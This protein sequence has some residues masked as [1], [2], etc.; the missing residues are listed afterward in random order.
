MLITSEH[1]WNILAVCASICLS[2]SV[3]ICVFQSCLMT[4][5]CPL[6][7]MTLWAMPASVLSTY[8]RQKCVVVCV[9]VCVCVLSVSVCICV[10]QCVCVLSVSVCICVFSLVSL[11]HLCPPSMMTLWAIPVCVC[12]CCLS[13]Y[14]FVCFSFVCLTHLCP[15]SVMTLWAI[16]GSEVC[17]SVCVCVCVCVCH[18][19]CVVCQ[20]V[21][22][23]VSVLSV[24]LTYAHRPWWLCELCQPQSSACTSDKSPCTWL[25]PSFLLIPHLQTYKQH[26]IY[27][28]SI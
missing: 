14:V 8:L 23:C 9:C 25:R 19:V 3:C 27:N 7:I 18:C 13:V 6:S 21:H 22:L 17:G 5:L 24:W 12:V 2:Y 16:P 10:F 26:N 20:C 4:H 28:F 15:P 1:L 11:T